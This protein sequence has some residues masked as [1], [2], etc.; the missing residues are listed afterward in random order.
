M[1]FGPH[2]T[3]GQLNASNPGSAHILDQYGNPSNPLAHI[4]GTAEDYRVD[5]DFAVA[6]RFSRFD[7]TAATARNV[8]RLR[9]Q[10]RLWQEDLKLRHEAGHRHI[11]TRGR[12][13][14]GRMTMMTR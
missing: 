12:G 10:L 1:A 14:R 2:A 3:L 8:S 6:F 13:R 9:G 5:S 7:A 4:E 11:L